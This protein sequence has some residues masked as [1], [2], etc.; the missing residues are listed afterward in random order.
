MINKPMNKQD[1][2][3]EF[4]IE[5]ALPPR[6][7]QNIKGTDLAK[8]CNWWIEK[9]NLALQE[10][11]EEIIKKIEVKKIAWDGKLP[12]A[13]KY[14]DGYNQALDDIISLLSNTNTE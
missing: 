5:F 8:I 12:I 10:Q 4:T 2:R 9:L 14:A 3:D 13:I 6:C 11:Q 7:L 1:I